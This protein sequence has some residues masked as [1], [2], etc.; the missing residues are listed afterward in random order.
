MFCLALRASDA[1]VAYQGL[2]EPDT[3]VSKGRSGLGCAVSGAG[4]H[5]S[6]ASSAAQ[7]LSQP[8][9]CP[10]PPSAVLLVGAC[11]CSATGWQGQC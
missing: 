10:F 2:A 3:A 8:G 1:S 4:L 7:L 5:L 6:V 11:L 9:G